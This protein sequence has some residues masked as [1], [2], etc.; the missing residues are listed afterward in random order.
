[1]KLSLKYYKTHP[2]AKE[3][4]FA[5]RGS[6]CFD[7]YACLDGLER[8][9]VHQDTL[10]KEI[11]RPLKNGSIQIFNMERVLIPTGLI[12][13]IPVG[14]SVRLHSRSGL[15]WEQGLYLTNC[16][17]VID[18]DYVEPLYV[19][20]TNISQSP[21]SINNG[22]RICQAELVEKIH[23]DFIEVKKPPNQKTERNGGFGSTGK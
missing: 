3:P 5:T 11:E 17:G 13:D 4:V 2:S 7:L 20:M 12:L 8:Y 22:N 6:A 14:H 23:Y 10:D 1:M 18:W 21:K 9:K 19:M 15:V 16:E